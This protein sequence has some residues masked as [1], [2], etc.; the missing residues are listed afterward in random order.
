M[1]TNRT[2]LSAGFLLLLASSGMVETSLLVAQEG[3]GSIQ[4]VVKDATGASVPGAAV[5]VTNTATHVAQTTQTND[6]GRY[7]VSSLIVGPYAVAVTKDG[8]K[9]FEQSGITIQVG[10]NAEIDVSLQT[11]AVTESI[12]VTAEAPLVDTTSGTVGDVVDRERVASLP[13]NG[14]A[15]FDFVLLTPGAR[16]QYGATANSFNSRWSTQLALSVNGGPV[17]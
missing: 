1:R 16:N 17:G 15:A 14:R 10:Q 8:F 11:G 12:A 5:T 7:A 6:L 4:G 13:M 9:R 2:R 3:R